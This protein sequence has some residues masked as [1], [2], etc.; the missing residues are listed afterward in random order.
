MNRKSIIILVSI[1][2]LSACQFTAPSHTATP[3]PT[4]TATST[5]TLT[6]SPTNTSTPEPTRTPTLTPVPK[7]KMEV[8]ASED[9][10][11]WRIVSTNN[12]VTRTT[13]IDNGDS[14][15]KV[16]QSD[17]YFDLIEYGSI[18]KNGT[19]LIS[20]YVKRDNLEYLNFEFFDESRTGAYGPHNLLFLSPVQPIKISRTEYTRIVESF[21]IANAP[22]MVRFG[23]GANGRSTLWLKDLQI[24]LVE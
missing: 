21:S 3:L 13:E 5:P 14:V 2:V 16:V 23:I 18:L 15:A 20:V 24:C 10:R 11:D 19:Y 7:C 17:G 22:I 8:I 9:F 6:P 12:S 1:F 4:E